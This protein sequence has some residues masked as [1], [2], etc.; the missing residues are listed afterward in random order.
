MIEIRNGGGIGQPGQV[1]A[2]INAGH[3]NGRM[4][5]SLMRDGAGSFNVPKREAKIGVEGDG[6]ASLFRNI[7]RG[8][9]GVSEIG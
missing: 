3:G 4:R 5:H 1:Q 9:S 6:N 7:H 8:E 2:V